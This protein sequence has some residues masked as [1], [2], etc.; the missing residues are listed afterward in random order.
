MSQ[1]YASQIHTAR[2]TNEKTGRSFDLSVGNMI[3]VRNKEDGPQ[4]LKLRVQSFY[5]KNGEMRIMA[6]GSDYQPEEILSI[7][8]WVSNT[9]LLTQY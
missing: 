3:I 4:C 2:F 8:D 7:D 6:G 9:L 1:A 5:E